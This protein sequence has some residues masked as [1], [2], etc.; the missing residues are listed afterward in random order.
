MARREEDSGLLALWQEARDGQDDA[1][2][3][4]VEHL[5]QRV[6]EEEMTALLGAGPHERTPER[7][8]YRN[9]HSPRALKTRVGTIELEVP[10]DRE[11]RF[12]TQVFE[13]YQR[14]EKA[15]LLA[16]AEMY[17]QGVST[18]KVKEIT[19]ALCGLE[20]SRSQVS[21]LAKDL[22]GEIAAW[23]M[24]PLEQPY[25]YLVVDAHYEKVRRSR[26]VVSDGVLKVVGI[27]A[28]G[29]RE[30][31]GVWMAPLESEATWS[32]VFR[33]LIERGLEGVRYVVSDDHKGL[34]AAA[35]KH[36]P[37][38]LWHRCQVHFLRNML[39]HVR[40]GD[41]GQVLDLLR[42]ITQAASLQAAR[43]ALGSAVEALRG[44][45]PRLAD[46]LEEQGEEILAVYQLPAP[47][48]RLMR[49]TNMIERLNQEIRRRT[50]VIRI[51][52]DDASCLRL[53]AALAMEQSEEWAERR[54]LT[55]EVEKAPARERAAE[56]VSA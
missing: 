41:R 49:S 45:Y 13:R 1:L 12:Q 39:G 50:R 20:V 11:G 35:E 34:R 31:L 42:A 38:A 3:R 2:R 51:F 48:R 22:D 47:H 46:L 40:Q 27:G 8:G 4:L 28:D 55:M 9:G 53:T 24:R 33:E 17:V 19:E 16:I 30:V 29:Y 26:R 43:Q 14:S 44:P 23:R 37:Q 15:L 18:R 7:R 54:Y 36:F 52:P 21:E 10:R 56:M 5:V 25:P 6:L 32:E